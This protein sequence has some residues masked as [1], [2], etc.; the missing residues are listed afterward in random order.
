MV[1]ELAEIRT[2][3]LNLLA[4][5][6]QFGRGITQAETAT[7]GLGATVSK[8]SKIASAAFIAMGT[9]A[10]YA[11]I[12]IG[13]DAVQAAIEDEASQATLAKTLKNVTDATDAQIA[14]TEKWITKQQYATGFSDSTIRK[15]LENL[16]R[17]TDDL[18]EAQKLNTLAMDISRGTGKDLESVSLA[19]AKAHEGNLG[20]LTR[21]GVPLDE[22]IKKTGDFEAATKKLSDLFGGQASN[23]A[24]TYQGKL[25]IV[26]QR[27]GELKE[28]AGVKLLDVLGK[29]L[30]GINE[31]AMGFGGEQPNSLSNKIKQ[32]SN[33]MGYG[34][35]Q[36]G[37]YSLG[38]SLRDVADSFGKLFDALTGS[39]AE[40]SKNTLQTIADTLTAVA[41]AIDKVTR[42]YERA[43][44]GAILE[45]LGFSSLLG[46]FGL[47]PNKLVI[48]NFGRAN[49]GSVR[50][51]QAYTVG[52]FGKETF[53][54]TTS[55]RIVPNAG[56]G[57]VTINLNGI[58]DAESA[59]RSIERLLQ[60][61]GRRTAAI[62]LVGSPL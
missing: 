22:N 57:N 28:G 1:A 3:K 60:D 29:L 42:A 32:V 17:V 24:D 9:A 59:R 47:L 58:V 26:N 4:D 40:G 33:D 15:S 55:G 14:S 49:G 61:S 34:T 31:V 35:Q 52:E 54:P 27:L 7:T 8:V 23:Y 13:K 16:V 21:L 18:S 30:T 41:E 25:D 11:A 48:P 37:A 36:S 51:G 43:K 2:L 5:V 62:N 19:L 46:G 44:N 53:I 38:A 45:K 6:N 10:G 50:A 56:S 20:A 12:R 39:K